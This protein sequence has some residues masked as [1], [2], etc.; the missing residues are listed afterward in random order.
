[1]QILG[2]GFKRRKGNLFESNVGMFIQD[3]NYSFDCIEMLLGIP[4]PI[5]Q[6]TLLESLDDAFRNVSHRYLLQNHLEDLKAV[7]GMV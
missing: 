1:L 7:D 3:G 2:N 5:L 4:S 6:H